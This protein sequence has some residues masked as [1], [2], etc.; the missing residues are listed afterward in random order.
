M[1]KFVSSPY[2]CHSWL[3]LKKVKTDSSTG[4]PSASVSATASVTSSTDTIYDLLEV[5]VQ[6]K[7][8]FSWDLQQLRSDLFEAMEKKLQAQNEEIRKLK[9]ELLELGRDVDSLKH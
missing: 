4:S 1:L 9:S 7:L 5:I 6:L 8:Q 2:D 3:I